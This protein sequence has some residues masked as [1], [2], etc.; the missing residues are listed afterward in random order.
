[1]N[2]DALDRLVRQSLPAPLA[3]AW[4]QVAFASP[5]ADRDQRLLA[6]FATVLRFLLAVTLA[7]Y[8]RGPSSTPVNNALLAL[9]RPTDGQL[10]DVLNALCA[11]LRKRRAPA[12]FMP[13]LLEAFR[14]DKKGA[15]PLFALIAELRKHRNAH[16]HHDPAVA[17]IAT[18]LESKVRSLFEQL[19]WLHAYQLGVVHD[20]V[21][22]LGQDRFKGR[23][24]WLVG[25]VA[26]VPREAEWQGALRP[27]RVYV[28]REGLMLDLDPLVA[29]S[30]A[31]PHASLLLKELDAS[32][33]TLRRTDD[34]HGRDQS[35][36]LDDAPTFAAWHEI[37]RE[38]PAR[39]IAVDFL[40]A[41]WETLERRASSIPPAAP[42]Q[43]TSPPGAA[44]PEP[45]APIL[46]IPYTPPAV[47]ATVQGALLAAHSWS[48]ARTGIAAGAVVL[49]GVLV[50]WGLS[51]VRQAPAAGLAPD[52]VI[53]P[54][55]TFLMGSPEDEPGRDRG[56]VLHPVTL[57][58]DFALQ[59]AP[60][61][62]RDW[63]GLMQQL[64]PDIKPCDETCPIE[65]ISWFDA[66][67]Y[68]NARSEHEDLPTCYTLVGC[69]GEPARDFVC[70]RVDFAG[71]DCPGYRLPTEAEWEYA[72]R[73]GT[74]TATWAGDLT[75]LKKRPIDPVLD[76]LAWYGGNAAGAPR[77]VG[78]KQPNPWGLYDTL[79][80]VWEWCND[81][82]AAYPTG[83]MIDPLGPPLG[84]ARIARGGTVFVE[85]RF[86]RAARRGTMKPELRSHGIGVRLAR[87]IHGPG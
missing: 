45:L 86:I 30:P 27:G 65:Q 20:P 78:Q 31:A 6:A 80:N 44:A 17:A 70:E 4:R 14:D 58:R 41:K 7:D 84:N 22:P 1:M 49:L 39:C 24:A 2:D 83:A 12:P 8:V 61:T 73:A 54:A 5:G 74:S 33:G 53:I 47:A 48:H 72:T 43:T 38:M 76:N 32:A 64:P 18:T 34:G 63:L 10:T 40:H 19:A 57:T 82:N 26:T 15:T 37:Q 52:L 68:A 81:W 51:T 16:Q 9:A 13:E 60:S 59:R 87:T 28:K 62:R 35:A 67:A 50:G 71:L 55:G 25:E 46:S 77:P 42:P 56:E 21:M 79:G 36:T 69:T 3:A 66:V 85:A 23:I 11:H 75:E 29:W